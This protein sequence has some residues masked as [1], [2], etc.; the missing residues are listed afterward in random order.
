MRERFDALPDN[1]LATLI[2][3]DPYRDPLEDLFRK[4]SM[5]MAAEVAQILEKGPSLFTDPYVWKDVI[6]QYNCSKSGSPIVSSSLALITNALIENPNVFDEIK[7]IYTHWR[8][9]CSDG[10]A[11][12]D[13]G[14]MKP[15]V[16]EFESIISHV[17]YK[18]T[19]SSIYAALEN[20]GREASG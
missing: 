6:E 19:E 12:I 4:Q 13:A 17:R 8:Q 10:S 1:H 16:P 2:F 3:D 11:F 14:K 9:E 20:Q 18:Q 15:L 7:N 5:E